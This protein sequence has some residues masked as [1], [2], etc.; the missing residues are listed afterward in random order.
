MLFLNQDLT[1]DQGGD[2]TATTLPWFVAGTV[3]D[4]HAYAAKFM[5]RVN[6]SDASPL[7]SLTQVANANG[8]VVTPTV[9]GTVTIFIA[10]ADTALLPYSSGPLYYGLEVLSTASPAVVTVF[11]FARLL[12][13]ATPIH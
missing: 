9:N 8:S 13:N 11:Q 12:V 3:V 6:A 10:H 2:F 7:L 1:V 5:V 4:I